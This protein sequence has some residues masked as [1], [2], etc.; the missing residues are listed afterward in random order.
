MTALSFICKPEDP[1]LPIVFFFFFPKTNSNIIK[2]RYT[3]QEKVLHGETQEG[4]VEKTT[5]DL[6]MPVFPMGTAEEFSGFQS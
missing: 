3:S 2:A 1:A 5:K 6:W 4:T